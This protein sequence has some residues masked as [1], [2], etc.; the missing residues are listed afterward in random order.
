M[1]ILCGIGCRFFK[2]NGYL[3]MPNT[4]FLVGLVSY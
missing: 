3:A 4:H 1:I 2:Y